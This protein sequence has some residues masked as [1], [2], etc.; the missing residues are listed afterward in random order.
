MR[1]MQP[2]K[3]VELTM[4][5]MNA[6]CAKCDKLSFF[7]YFSSALYLISVVSL[8]IIYSIGNIGKASLAYSM[9]TI[10]VFCLPLVSFIG[11]LILCHIKLF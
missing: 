4:G 2:E 9:V 3:D 8:L 10:G 11:G 5:R 6:G 7:Q 1:R